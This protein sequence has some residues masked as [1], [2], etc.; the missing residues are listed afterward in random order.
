MVRKLISPELA[1]L[2]VLKDDDEGTSGGGFIEGYA[3]VFGNTDQGRDIV[4]RGA[5]RKTLK[6]RMPKGE[7]LLF[8]SHRIYDGTSAVIGKVVEAKEDDHG[9]W[10]KAQFSAVQLA[11]DI[12]TKVQ[13]GI[14]DALSF[15][16]DVVKYSIDENEKV[17]RLQELKLF[18]ISV[19]P[20]GMNPKALIA[21]V[22]GLNTEDE[23]PWF[24]TDQ[25]KS[26]FVDPKEDAGDNEGGE[27]D[28]VVAEPTADELELFQ[29]FKSASH[30][31]EFS[32][33]IAEMKE[34]AT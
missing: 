23:T 21:T 1:K 34:L 11:Q 30:D 25:Y 6:E 24:E 19:V 22:K 16:F 27:E 2:K 12:R 5:F 29:S 17:R 4:E 10:F 26:L 31:M 3:S 13:E 9:L 33:M 20:W 28:P 18:E 15:G 7:V 8:D 32:R 14:L